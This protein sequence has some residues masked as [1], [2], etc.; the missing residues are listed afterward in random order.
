MLKHIIVGI[1]EHRTMGSLFTPAI[2]LLNR[3]RYPQ[4][5][6]L[7]G[8]LMLLPLLLVMDEYIRA[9][10]D[11]IDFAGKE[12]IGLKYAAPLIKL[13]EDLQQHWGLA[14]AS[15]AGDQTLAPQI[16]Q[17]DSAIKADIQAIDLVDAQYGAALGVTGSWTALKG[18]W[19]SMESGMGSMMSM[20]T[21]DQNLTM[22]SQLSAAT[23]QLI[24]QVGNNSN[25]I[26]DPN[27]DS[28]YLMDNV[29]NKLPAL[30]GQVGQIRAYGVT[31]AVNKT[32]ADTDRVRLGIFSELAHSALASS[33]DSYGY[34]FGANADLKA[35]LQT[36]TN[37]YASTING[38]VDS[39][40]KA[41]AD[42]KGAL[43]AP[44]MF[45]D[46]A[47]RAV[48]A[49]FT[50]YDKTTPELNNLLQTRIDLNA[51]QRNVVLAVAL[52]A[53]A[54]VVYLFVAFYLA[55]RRTINSL[56]QATQRMIKGHTV[57]EFRLD[58]RD[59]LAQ[60]AGSFNKIAAELVTARDQALDLSRAKSTFLATMSHELR[61]PLNAII[62]YSELIEEECED[63]GQAEYIP[64]LK[65]IQ[66]AARHLLILINDI[67]DLSKIEAGKMELYIEVVDVPKMINDIQS[68]VVPL[69]EKNGNM[70]EVTLSPDVSLMRADLTKVRQILFNLISNAAKFTKQGRI[71]LNVHHE[72]ISD[73]DWM[74]FQVSDSGIGMTPAQLGKLFQE[75][76]QADSS[77]TRKYGG[78][79][80]GLAIS[81]HFCQMMGGDIT[82][83]SE[84][85]KGST[86]TVRLPVAVP[87]QETIAIDSSGQ[88]PEGA[89][90]VLVID[91]DP[92]TRDLLARFLL[93]EGYHVEVATN[94]KDGL[95]RARDTQP[96]VI[97]LDVMMPGMDGWAVLSKLKADAD[98]APIPVIMISIAGDK[99]IGYALGAADYL[100]KP[101]GRDHLLKVLEKYECAK[102][103]CT[104]LLIEDDPAMRE[105]FRRALQKENL[106]VIEA[107]DGRAGLQQ[108]ATHSP[109]LIF[110][111]LMM[112]N[113]N[114]FEFVSELR[115]S[116]HGRSIPVVVV[117][118]MD[119]TP[120]DRARLNGHVQSVVQKGAYAGDA[121]FAELRSLVATYA[122]QTLTKSRKSAEKVPA[123]TKAN[124]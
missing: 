7:V 10:N 75:F 6:A 74:V 119:L 85:G 71:T 51:A 31:V 79:G 115:R 106:T 76:T 82:A 34:A 101:I 109:D 73:V 118:A 78:T 40:N 45:F 124:D 3:L 84:Y 32:M 117:T 35:R 95:Q 69:V 70:L 120:Q 99:S 122:L 22:H 12:Q 26:L 43:G 49:A 86:F 37:Q 41:I 24:V 93:H 114:G 108:V 89:R 77:T 59:E 36:A 103:V 123:G 94:G 110:L 96:D 87:K 54:M 27:L 9:E 65:K 57:E 88:V 23:Q 1:R 28:Y 60:V 91:D 18:Q 68:T 29:I 11:V 67:L 121:L 62:G 16:N 100:A 53:L 4:K 58:N 104:V 21:I 64:D 30:V 38:F 97:I 15:I 2:R 83:E 56:D 113:M 55:V 13:F 33:S 52:V 42:P 81:K 20:I 19:D 46:T 102:P 39:L 111:D 63:S 107:A 92:A 48:D 66:A 14:N 25:L 44:A 17:N 116:V 80:L 47:T 8:L 98:L 105:M 50:I 90:T 112:P 5:F 61:T 72:T